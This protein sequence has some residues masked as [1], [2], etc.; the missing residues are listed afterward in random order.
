MLRFCAALASLALAAALFVVY[1]HDNPTEA[2]AA[3]SAPTSASSGQSVFRYDTFGDEQLWTD[4]LEMQKAIATVT[5]RTALS[6]GLKVDS[7]ALPPSLITAIRNGQVNLDDP[8]VTIQLLKLMQLWG[9]RKSRRPEEQSDD[10][11]F[12]L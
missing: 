12:A 1:P 5:P 6:V 8:A 10:D 9:D 4:V 3:A 2:E 11:R 7:D